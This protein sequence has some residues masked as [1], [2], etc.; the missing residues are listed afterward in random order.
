[1]SKKKVST[2]DQLDILTEPPVIIA[3]G[4]ITTG[5]W[6]DAELIP[7]PSS[8]AGKCEFD[9][10]VQP[11]DGPVVQVISPIEASYK[12]SPEERGT[13]ISSFMPLIIKREFF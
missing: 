9:F 8:S 10:V 11:P 12:L 4:T 7:R 6:T 13:T 1:M 3:S 2:V 5:G